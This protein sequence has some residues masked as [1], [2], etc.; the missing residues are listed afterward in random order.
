MN[1][2][3][4]RL[5]FCLVAAMVWQPFP[6]V[7]AQPIRYLAQESDE[8]TEKQKLAILDDI[9]ADE[10]GLKLPLN[11]ASIGAA[12][13]NVLWDCDPSRARSLI[14]GITSQFAAQASRIDPKDPQY[15]QVNQQVSSAR[16]GPPC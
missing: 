4:F 2:S 1:A 10:S 5:A 12:V 3:L 9:L 13:A 8:L 15:N 14:T 11:Q 16:H 7:A 6:P